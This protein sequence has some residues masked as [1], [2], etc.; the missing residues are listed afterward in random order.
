MLQCGKKMSVSGRG[1][2]EEEGKREK[3]REARIS[4]FPIMLWGF[5]SSE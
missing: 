2:G 4:A 5:Y 1:V 3:E